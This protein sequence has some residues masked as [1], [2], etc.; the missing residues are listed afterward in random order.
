MKIQSSPFRILSDTHILQPDSLTGFYIILR[1]QPLVE[2]LLERVTSLLNNF[3]LTP[4]L[5]WALALL[6]PLNVLQFHLGCYSSSNFLFIGQDSPILI[7]YKLSA[8]VTIHPRTDLEHFHTFVPPK[9][10]LSHY[11]DVF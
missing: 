9:I 2:S 11:N 1:E 8:L 4:I 10:F 3:H 7:I 5:T 6:Q